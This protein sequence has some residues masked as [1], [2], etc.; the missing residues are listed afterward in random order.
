MDAR[1]SVFLALCRWV[2]ALT[3]V[4]YH[5]RFLLFAEYGDVASS[6]YL[7]QAFYFAT[8]LGHEAL[9]AF[10]VLE[11][12][13]AARIFTMPGFSITTAGCRERLLRLYSF[14]VPALLLG[15]A[16]DWIGAGFAGQR[17]LYQ[18]YT[19]FSGASLDWG[20]FL[21]NLGMLQPF[22]APAFGSNQMLSLYAFLF[23]AF[24]LSELFLLAGIWPPHRRVL[25]RAALV[26][27][28]LA[29]MPEQFLVWMAIW[30][31]GVGVVLHARAGYRPPHL[32]IALAFL[33]LATLT[34][35][36][37]GADE[38]LLPAPFG[39]LLMV[40][41]YFF[42]GLG[43]AALAVACAPVHARRSQ[44][45]PSFDARFMMFFHFPFMMIACAALAV[46]L[47]PLPL[48]QPGYV[49]V[50]LF[51]LVFLL[52]IVATLVAGRAVLRVSNMLH[53]RMFV[54]M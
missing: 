1:F 3:M 20:V 26:A 37:I 10:F 24:V 22:F 41:R 18:R 47:G 9:A 6:N 7:V 53:T 42:V 4:G 39:R 25:V 46:W 17:E 14:Y 29:L 36:M 51:C 13:A 50:G 8:G 30:L 5:L 19:E 16:L 11:G 54:T 12:I 38:H 48:M 35:R 40:W 15:G 45:R 52:T 49:S 31:L 21:A 32:L 2:A 34:S 43:A 28:V 23:W 27:A 33:G 44:E